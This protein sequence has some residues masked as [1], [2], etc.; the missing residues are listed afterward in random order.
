[1]KLSDFYH[2]SV[3][4]DGG[5]FFHS[6]VAILEVEEKDERTEARQEMMH[7]QSEKKNIEER[8][9]PKR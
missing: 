7:K 4:G 9:P 5:C 1:M 8:R 3:P 2:L 6:I